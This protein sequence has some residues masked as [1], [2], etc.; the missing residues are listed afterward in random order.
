MKDQSQDNYLTIKYYLNKGSPYSPARDKNAKVTISS[1]SSTSIELL[2]QTS[3]NDV[4]YCIV[5]ITVPAS[6]VIDILEFQCLG[7]ESDECLFV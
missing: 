5:D 6:L 7:T 2:A 1:S 3:K 4:K